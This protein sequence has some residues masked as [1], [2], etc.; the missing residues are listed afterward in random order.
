MFASVRIGS[1]AMKDVIIV[2]KGAVLFRDNRPLVFTVVDGQAQWTYVTPGK[3]NEDFYE[4]KENL[5]VGDT[6]VV[7][8]NYNLA[9][10]AKVRIME[11]MKY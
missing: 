6:L 4:I 5:A 2:P 7:D 9:H 8:G 11:I 3:M 1:Q 10:Q